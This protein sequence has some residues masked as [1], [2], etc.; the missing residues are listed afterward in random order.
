MHKV[1]LH[2]LTNKI[3]FIEQN[4]W[5]PLKPGWPREIEPLSDK[6]WKWLFGLK[7]HSN[8]TRHF[9]A[10]GGGGCHENVSKCHI[11]GGGLSMCH[12]TCLKSFLT[13]LEDIFYYYD[14]NMFISWANIY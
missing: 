4:H 6:F 1:D 9:L 10:G 5:P 13:F 14:K 2:E 7:G 3:L 11:G 8:N 12:V